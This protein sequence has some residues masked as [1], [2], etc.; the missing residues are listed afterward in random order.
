MHE[1][2]RIIQRILISHKWAHQRSCCHHGERFLKSLLFS[3]SYSSTF[4]RVYSRAYIHIKS[5]RE[6]KFSKIFSIKIF[7]YK[8][9]QALSKNSIK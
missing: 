5:L 4:T 9:K 2:C 1:L 7:K 3:V 6:N 8:S